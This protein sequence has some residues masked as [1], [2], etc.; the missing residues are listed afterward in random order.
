MD[1]MGQS[2]LKL[3]FYDFTPCLEE[4]E[5]KQLQKHVASNGTKTLAKLR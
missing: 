5:D 1:Q 4:N 2:N 3:S